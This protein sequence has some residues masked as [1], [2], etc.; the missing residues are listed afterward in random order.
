V[1]G[2]ECPGRHGFQCGGVFGVGRRT[3]VAGIGL[4]SVHGA[5][6][7]DGRGRDDGAGSR[8]GVAGV[9]LQGR[10]ECRFA[11]QAVDRRAE[12]GFHVQFRGR[13]DGDFGR[14]A[15]GV[16]RDAGGRVHANGAHLQGGGAELGFGGDGHEE[17][18]GED[19]AGQKGQRGRDAPVALTDTHYA[20]LL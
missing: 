5:V 7:A 14:H 6:V 16:D 1:R 17:T 10:T 19:G 2:G 11:A 3:H 18:Q 8:F 20:F 13:L 4:P 15:A 9:H 12:C